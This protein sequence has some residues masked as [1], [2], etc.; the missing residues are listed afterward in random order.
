MSISSDSSF[1]TRDSVRVWHFTW[2]WGSELA[3]IPYQGGR[4]EE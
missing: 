3:F 2:R 1:W 4:R